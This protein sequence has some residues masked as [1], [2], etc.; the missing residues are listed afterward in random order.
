MDPGEKALVISAALNAVASSVGALASVMA[1]ASQNRIA[2]IDAEIKAEKKRD[3]KSAASVAKIKALERKK[4]QS[5]RKAFEQ[6]KKMMMAQAIISTAAAAA[7]AYAL[8]PLP[9]APW[10]IALAALITAMGLA[11]VAIISGMTYQGGGGGGGV[12]A[13]GSISV[14]QRRQSVDTAKSRG[15]AGE[16]AY[17]RGES[18]RGGPE[19][20]RGAFYGK[21]HRAM[22]GA[23][24]Y[25]VGEQGPELFMPARPGTIV[26]AD[27][28]AAAAGAAGAVTFNINTVDATGVEDLLMEQQGNI[29]GMIRQA[30]NSYGE[31]FMEDV[32]VTAFTPAAVRRA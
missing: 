20:F 15:G 29:I 3:G 4:E 31:E 27:D 22:G 18:G 8:P 23:T 1:A 6:N 11:Q 30:A 7:G 16:L 24:G 10:N 14:G 21:R 17:F 5:A 25:V 2:V 26:P 19:D 12:S 32:D 28:T 13:P 9:G